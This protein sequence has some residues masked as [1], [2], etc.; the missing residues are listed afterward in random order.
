MDHA[1]PA[2]T[3][4]TLARL[5]EDHL[6]DLVFRGELRP[7]QRLVNER[8][9]TE[10]G[11]S[12]EPVREALRQLDGTGLVQIRE[13]RG[14]IIAEFD[15]TSTDELVDLLRVRRAL[16]PWVAGE[17]ARRHRP[18][19]VAA[20]DR[21][22]AAGSAALAADDH[23]G[24]GR[25]HHDVLQSIARAAHNRPLLDAVTPLHNRTALAFSLVAVHTLPDGWPAH[26]QVRDAIVAGDGRGAGRVLR[27]HLDAVAS[28]VRRAPAVWRAG[29]AG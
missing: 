18:E 11:I 22:L 20:I 26:R 21:A 24:A 25:A 12:R 5:V 13:R 19:D 7:G 15:C 16:D 29:V 1:Q 2:T 4:P 28:A 14:A 3:K 8:I 10:L 27:A 9:A 23:A 6:R 17:A